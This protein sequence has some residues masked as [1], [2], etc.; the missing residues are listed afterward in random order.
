MSAIVMRLRFD[1]RGNGLGPGFFLLRLCISATGHSYYIAAPHGLSTRDQIL[2]PVHGE[3]IAILV[4]VAQVAG[5][6]PTT[7][8]HMALTSRP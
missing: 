8:E 6:Q 7:P 2:L 5:E 4:H 3:E 1:S